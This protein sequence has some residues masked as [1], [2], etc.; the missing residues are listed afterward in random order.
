MLTFGRAIA[1]LAQGRIQTDPLISH[2][3][4]LT[5]LTEG[6]ATMKAGRAVKALVL[7]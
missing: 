3:F 4:A 1:L 6:I 2:R 7:P 5:S